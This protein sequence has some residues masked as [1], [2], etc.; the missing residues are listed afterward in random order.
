MPSAPRNRRGEYAEATRTAIVDAARL[1]F[2]QKGFFA[3]TVDEV[4]REARVAPATVYAVAGGK[5]GLIRTLIDLWSTA[6]IVA[7][8]L[9]RQAELDD[10]DEILQNAAAA[11]RSMREDYGDIMR[12]VLATAPHNA[13]V[14]DDLA[15][16]NKRYRDAIGTLAVRLH[17]VGGPRPDMTVQDATDTLWFFL[18]YSGYFTLVDDLGWSYDRAEQWLLRQATAALRG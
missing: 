12:M 4:A 6:P 2:A 8:T 10:P 1:L 9:A 14:G 3:T 13:A 15:I 16:A 11:V 18:G 17:E 5:R 7:E